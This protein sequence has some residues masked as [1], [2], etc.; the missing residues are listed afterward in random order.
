M[1][2]QRCPVIVDRML[3]VKR[4][5]PFAD[6]AQAAHERADIFRPEHHSINVLP[7]QADMVRLAIGISD[8]AKSGIKAVEEPLAVKRRDVGPLA[9]RNDYPLPSH[10]W[11]LL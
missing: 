9:C 8:H 11:L 6:D 1:R 10:C 7:A 2:L 3:H 5:S 4:V